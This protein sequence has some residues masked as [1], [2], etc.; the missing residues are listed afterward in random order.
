MCK[1]KLIDN[2]EHKRYEFDIDG[3]RPQLE[4]IKTGGGEIYLT[5]TVVPDALSGRGIGSELVLAALED[6]D[7]QGLKIIPLCGFVSGYVR[8]NP[9]WE[10]LLKDGLDIE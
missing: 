1:N 2:A 8:K 9:Q 3:L 10:R 5:H 6:I 7:R 4:Y